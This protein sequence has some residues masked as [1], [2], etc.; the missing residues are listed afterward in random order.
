MY[1]YVSDRDWAPS[2]EHEQ[3]RFLPE[4]VMK[5]SHWKPVWT[6]EGSLLIPPSGHSQHTFFPASYCPEWDFVP[7][8]VALKRELFYPYFLWAQTWLYSPPPYA[9]CPMSLP[10]PS[11]FTL[12]MEA[13]WSSETLVSYHI[14]TWCHNPE[15]HDL[16]TLTK[17]HSSLY[18][19]LSAS[20][21]ESF[22]P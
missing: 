4:Q 5:A 13:A 19:L 2:R 14:I 22:T 16:R 17:S 20:W 18:K 12:N 11:L 1:H 8:G 3:W 7:Q 10:R 21:S 9:P 6:K 15:D